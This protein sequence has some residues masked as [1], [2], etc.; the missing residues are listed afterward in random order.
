MIDPDLQFSV[1][2]DDIRREDNGKLMFFGLFEAV[3]TTTMPCAH[4]KL[5]IAN[6]WCNGMGEFEQQ[7]RLVT[8]DDEVLVED[9]V[10]RF[11]LPGMGASHTVIAVFG[12]LRFEQEGHYSVEVLLN[13]NLKLRYPLVVEEIQEGGEEQM[14]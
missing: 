5:C 4:P 7:T 13:G 14:A 3:R 10:T 8:V 12:G 9:R 11:E 1:L 2:C 6:R